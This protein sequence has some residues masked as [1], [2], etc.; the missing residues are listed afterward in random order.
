MTRPALDHYEVTVAPVGL[1]VT[2]AEFKEFAKL[3]ADDDSQDALLTTF[4]E[5]ARFLPLSVTRLRKFRKRP[6]YLCRKLRS[7]LAALMPQRP[8]T[9]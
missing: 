6:C 9:N 1:P 3:D 8:T 7:G 5:A 4:L 2:L